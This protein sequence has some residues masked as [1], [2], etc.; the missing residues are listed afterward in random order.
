MKRKELKESGEKPHDILA[1]AR[2]FFERDF[3]YWTSRD[4]I[5]TPHFAIQDVSSIF[6]DKAKY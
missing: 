3:T 2:I 4:D 6:G 5:F 1:V